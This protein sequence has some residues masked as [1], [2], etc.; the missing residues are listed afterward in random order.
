M[1]TIFLVSQFTGARVVVILLYKAWPWSPQH[2]T[3]PSSY[4][5]P[6]ISPIHPGKNTQTN[7]RKWTECHMCNIYPSAHIWLVSLQF[8]NNL[9]MWNYCQDIIL[10][11]TTCFHPLWSLYALHYGTIFY[12]VPMVVTYLSPQTLLVQDSA[13]WQQELSSS[14]C[15]GIVTGF[16]STK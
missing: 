3:D 4:S 16:M 10:Y 14:C 2:L 6:T 13:G 9:K 1:T 5:I 15:K 7:Y 8:K 11:F 12:A